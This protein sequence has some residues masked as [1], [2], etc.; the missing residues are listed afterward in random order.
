MRILRG[1]A[2]PG[3]VRPSGGRE[4]AGLNPVARPLINEEKN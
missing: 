4:V 1:V 2:Q 3:L